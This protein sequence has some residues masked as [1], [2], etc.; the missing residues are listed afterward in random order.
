MRRYLIILKLL[1]IGTWQ[2]NAGYAHE[3]LFGLGPHTVGQYAWAVESE[4]ER[5]DHGWIL[6]N[7][8]LYGITPD[9]AVTL[10]VPYVVSHEGNSAGLGDVV[11]RGKYRFIRRDF[12]KGSRAMALHWGIKWPTGSQS[13]GLGSGT[14]DY[15]VGLSFGLESRKHYAFAAVRYR[16]QGKYKELDPGNQFNL[17]AAYGIRLW[18]LEYLQPD[19]VLLVEVLGERIS[20]TRLQEITDPNSGGSLISLAPG[21]LFSYRN[22]M[23][24]GGVKIPVW[25]KLHGEQES[26]GA[27]FVLAVDLHMPPFK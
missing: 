15:F 24:K 21:F 7:E 14:R 16:F 4:L 2:I 23:I 5:G 26:P 11:F 27:E 9:V 6:H 18:Q 13:R 19:L 12:F 25:E 17:E 20:K 10:A 22:V 3:P 8:F 1:I